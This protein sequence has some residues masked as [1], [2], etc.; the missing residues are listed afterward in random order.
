MMVLTNVHSL[1]LLREKA[2][3]STAIADDELYIRNNS[4]PAYFERYT[5]N[6]GAIC[7]TQGVGR[8]YMHWVSN[9]H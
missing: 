2:I 1:S 3:A 8:G 7:L 6:S 9:M 4:P 5:P